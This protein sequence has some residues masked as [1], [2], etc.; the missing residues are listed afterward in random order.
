[1]GL[2]G[3]RV[4]PYGR[5]KFDHRFRQPLQSDKRPRESQPGWSIVRPNR[6][7]P[8]KRWYRLIISA[9]LEERFAQKIVGLLV[10]GIQ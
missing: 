10:S 6:D 2:G 7:R 9:K 5:G 3:S 1:M 8:L 4:E